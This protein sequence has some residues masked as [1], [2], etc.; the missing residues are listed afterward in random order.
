MCVSSR[1]FLCIDLRVC[2]L[3]VFFAGGR[4]QVKRHT[5]DTFLNLMYPAVPLASPQDSPVSSPPTPACHAAPTSPLTADPQ[6][7]WDFS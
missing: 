3:C 6:G 4:Q 7:A 5:R 1:I 2:Y